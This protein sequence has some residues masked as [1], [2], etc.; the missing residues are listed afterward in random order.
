[1]GEKRI[2]GILIT[3]L[4]SDKLKLEEELERMLN[5]NYNIEKKVIKVKKI[6]SKINIIELNINK[7]KTY[8]GEDLTNNSVLLTDGKKPK[9]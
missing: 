4:T 5:L 2:F 6:L 3:D 7:L 9:K 8:I 1:M